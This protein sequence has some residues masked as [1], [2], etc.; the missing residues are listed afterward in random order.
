[1]DK[2]REQFEAKKGELF[3]KWVKERAKRLKEDIV[4]QKARKPE[5]I[6][7]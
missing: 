6:K 5:V 4:K 1:M 3:E 2:F 7:L